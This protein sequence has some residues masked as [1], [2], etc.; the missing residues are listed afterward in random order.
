[1][2]GKLK[3]LYL[4]RVDLEMMY[5]YLWELFNASLPHIQVVNWEAIDAKCSAMILARIRFLVLGIIDLIGIFLK[6]VHLSQ[7][8]DVSKGF[9][10][11]QVL[12][13]GFTFLPYNYHCGSQYMWIS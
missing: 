2:C 9:G 6:Q 10:L 8:S 3:I 7:W 1:M 5:W 4:S 11:H 12:L 13:F